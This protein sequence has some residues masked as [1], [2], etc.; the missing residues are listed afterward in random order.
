MPREPKRRSGEPQ[1]ADASQPPRDQRT[2]SHGGVTGAVGVGG[3]PDAKLPHERDESTGHAA[4]VPSGEG[5][6]AYEDARRGM[7]DTDKA[8]VMDQTYHKV[9]K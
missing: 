4:D 8:P 7:P 1:T 5:R 2:T 9:R 3:E 6:R